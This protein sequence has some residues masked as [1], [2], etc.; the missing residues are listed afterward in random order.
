MLTFIAAKYS[1]E[2]L[3]NGD[4]TKPKKVQSIQRSGAIQMQ[5]IGGTLVADFFNF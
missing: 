5:L 1:K 4:W 2:I 3:P